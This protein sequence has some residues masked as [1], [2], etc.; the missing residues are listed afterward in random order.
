MAAHPAAVRR[1]MQNVL[2]S[3]WFS[4]D[5]R[6]SRRAPRGAARAAFGLL[7]GRCSSWE[8]CVQDQPLDPAHTFL[9]A[10]GITWFSWNF[11]GFQ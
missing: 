2:F 10:E 6:G 3:Q 8:K 7:Q 9:P 5:S 4:M 11:I 1:A